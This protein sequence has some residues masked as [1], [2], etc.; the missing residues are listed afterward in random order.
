[1][2]EHTY[3][4]KKVIWGILSEGALCARL[5]N[6]ASAYDFTPEAAFL[7]VFSFRW[8]ASGPW[9]RDAMTPPSPLLGQFIA[10]D[11]GETGG[12]PG[13]KDKEIRVRTG[14][15]PVMQAAWTKFGKLPVFKWLCW[16]Y[17]T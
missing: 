11:W 9:L 15:F 7:L 16:K 4:P 10:D 2:R 12:T 6:R 3:P 17:G 14:K 5:S 13:F 8:S 1:M